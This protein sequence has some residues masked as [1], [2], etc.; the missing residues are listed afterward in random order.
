[1]ST[2]THSL[3]R[4]S[5]LAAGGLGAS[6]LGLAACGG[7]DD[8]SSSGGGGGATANFDERGPI[9]FATGKDT[10]GVLKEFL[11]RWNKDHEDEKVTL[12]ELPESADDQRSQFINNAQ[13]KSDAYSVLGLDVVWTAEFA[14][15]QWVVELPKD[16][17]PIDAMIPAT[18]ET[19]TYFGKLYA[20]PFA[21]NGQLLFSRKD[22]LEDAGVSEPP[23]TYDEMYQIIEKVQGSNEG[24]NGFGGQFS[25]Y[26]GLTCQIS[27]V[28]KSAG[29]E[30]FDKDGKPHADSKEAVEGLQVLRDGFDKK[31]IPQEAL[32]YK[33]E[34][35]RQAFQDGKLVFLQNWPYVYEKF[36]ADDG[37]SKV[38]GKVLV[39]LVPAVTG[40]GTSTVG[41]LNY[42]ISAFAKNM[43]TALDFIAFMGAPEQQK[44]WFEQ[45]SNPTAS[46]AV[47][48]DADLKK[49]YPF[50]ATLKDSIDKGAVRPQVVKYGEVTQAIQEAAYGCLSGDTDAKAAM[51]DL[52]K[53]LTDLTKG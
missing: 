1:M 25:K 11:E 45:T 36:E 14:A 37:S 10:S 46:K 49:K 41:G 15:N 29:G 39:S 26:E 34:E 22:L 24:M 30:L 51:S 38:N 12:V 18:V 52:Q 20:M 3:P 28:V 35:S 42:A 16:K 7:S 5:L 31:Y 48:E 44:A 17:L 21:T 43:G 40:E 8:S 2:S 27:G 53:Q 6:A 23:A 50:L 33:E 9:T 13:A 32:T 19:A 47:F 4:R